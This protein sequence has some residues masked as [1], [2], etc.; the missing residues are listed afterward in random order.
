MSLLG[1]S[2]SFDLKVHSKVGWFI[3]LYSSWRVGVSSAWGGWEGGLR[4][5]S[6][7]RLRGNGSVLSVRWI[8]FVCR[9]HIYK[10]QLKEVGRRYGQRTYF[11][12]VFTINTLNL[13]LL[14]V[15]LLLFWFS[16]VAIGS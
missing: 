3:Y 9:L 14:L 11:K 13:L 4:M 8:D 10:T 16:V 7:V 12:V 5:E 2:Q 1:W 15:L 6:C